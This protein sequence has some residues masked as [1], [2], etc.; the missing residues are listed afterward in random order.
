MR[1]I[2]FVYLFRKKGNKDSGGGKIKKSPGGF[3][4]LFSRTRSG[5][6]RQKGRKPSIH[7][8]FGAKVCKVYTSELNHLFAKFYY[9]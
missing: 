2:C 8:K 4:S 7:G 1:L 6:I 5:S 9:S 3:R